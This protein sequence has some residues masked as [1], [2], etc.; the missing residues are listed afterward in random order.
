MGFSDRVIKVLGGRNAQEKF[1]NIDISVSDFDAGRS[2][3][4]GTVDIFP[5]TASKGKLAL[6]AADSSGD[7]TTTF[8]NASQAAARTYTIPDAGANASFLM[9]QGAQTIVG[10]QTFSAAA[11]FNSTVAVNGV[12]SLDNGTGAASA[13]AVLMGRGT[14][15]DPVT[16]SSANAKFIEFR[17]QSSATSGDN[18]LLYMRYELSGTGGGECLRCFTK[19]QGTIDTARGAHISIDF[20]S[21]VGDKV[22]GLA[23]GLDCQLLLANKVGEAGIGAHCALNVEIWSG[24]STTDYATANPLAFIRINNGGDATGRGR[25]D[26]DAF[27]MSIQ[28]LTVGD[29]AAD[30]VWINTITAATINARVTEALK[31]QIGGNTRYIPI[32]TAT[33]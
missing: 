25:V 30:K 27:L 15:A 14:T 1:A 9:T 4:A 28:G 33:T 2:G 3:A 18:R 5:A 26:D 31:I 12:M 22:T 29:E 20:D 8:V 17:C 11:I 24:G 16:T 23:A 13:S 32:A 21:T 10:A 7:T 6:T 19:I